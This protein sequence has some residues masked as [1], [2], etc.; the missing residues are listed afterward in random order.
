M[1]A[2]AFSPER[3]FHVLVVDDSPADALVLKNLSAILRLYHPCARCDRPIPTAEF[4]TAPYSSRA[5]G[6]ARVSARTSSRPPSRDN[7]TG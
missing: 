4:S 7:R 6:R 1:S 3:V 5:T 2:D